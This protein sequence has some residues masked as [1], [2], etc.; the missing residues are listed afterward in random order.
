MTDVDLRVHSA[1]QQVLSTIRPKIEVILRTRGYY[2][3]SDLILQ[4]K[5]QIW[6]LIERDLGG[7]FHAAPSLLIKNI[8]AE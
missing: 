2:G 4:F 6:G 7:Y 1:V 5:I 3:T 8:H